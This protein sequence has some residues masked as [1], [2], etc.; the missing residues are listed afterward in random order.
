M[1]LIFSLSF[2]LKTSKINEF[3]KAPI[4]ARLTVDGARSE[5][6]TK[7]YIEPIKWISKAG[8]VKGSGEESKTINYFLNTV[9]FKINEHH[10]LLIEQNKP[11]TIETLKNAYLGITEKSKSIKEVFEYHN[12][13]IKSLIGKDFSKGTYTIFCTALKHTQLL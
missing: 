7:K 9:R 6:A 5:F 3:G 4:Y 1:P 11:V 12:N 13:Q 8:A 10:R 2:Q